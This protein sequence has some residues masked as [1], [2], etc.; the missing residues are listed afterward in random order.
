MSHSLGA[1]FAFGLF[2]LIVT[3]CGISFGASESETEIFKELTV[4]GDFRPGGSLT[5]TLEY[6]QQYPVTIDVE[7]ALFEIEP[8]KTP[9]AATATSTP[10]SELTPTP[11]R[12]PNP[13][14]TPVNKVVD[15]LAETLAANPEGG[16]VDEATPVP[17][18]FERDFFAPERSGK[19]VV[20]CFT[21]DDDNNGIAESIT[22]KPAAGA[23]ATP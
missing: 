2:A 4:E 17:G 13:R 5:M 11:V 1:L 16:P 6:A 18:V 9:T 23:T 22:I 19:Y 15:I 12:I 20:L 21:P 3:G 14:S 10:A 8:E 7:C